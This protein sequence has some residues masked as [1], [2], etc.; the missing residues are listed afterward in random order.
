MRQVTGVG[1]DFSLQHFDAGMQLLILKPPKHSIMKHR[2]RHSG[3][4]ETDYK[5]AN[6]EKIDRF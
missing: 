1:L 4:N 5:R 2:S 6:A 3:Y